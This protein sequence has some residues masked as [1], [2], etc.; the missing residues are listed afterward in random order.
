MPSGKQSRRR[1]QVAAPP[2]RTRGAARQA[3]PRVLLAAGGAI[4]A[5]AAAVVL[6][7]VLTRGGSSNN[8]PTTS[9][10]PGAADV[11]SLLSG[12]PQHG[13][14]LG[15]PSAPVTMIEYIDL[16]CPF[17]QQFETSAMPTIVRRYV[18]TGKLKVEARPIAF[19]GPDSKRGRDAALAAG[20]QGKLF[21]FAQ[22]LY[23][24]QGEENTG[25]L[26]DA[27]VKSAATS[28]PGLNV[29]RLLDDRSSS[30][31]SDDEH[32][33]DADATADAVHATPTILV[34]RTGSKPKVVN[35][36]SPTDA[37]SVERAIDAALSAG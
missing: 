37:Q 17:C 34:G 27:M 18:R 15:K 29:T 16:Q 35:L 26:D 10:L 1:R 11:T 19:I 31:V 12:I 3:S 33:F 6:A 23:V 36:A 4:A 13:N 2:V 14:V 8:G 32:A 24:N 7:V 21:D 25:W 28:I 5:I 9:T 22:L 30:A 20:L